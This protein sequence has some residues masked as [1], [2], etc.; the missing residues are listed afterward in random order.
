MPWLEDKPENFSV[1]GLLAPNFTFFARIDTVH[2][3]ITM[4]LG[5][6]KTRV[7]VYSLLPKIYFNEPDFEERVKAYQE[8]Q[9]RVMSEDRAML[10]SMQNGLGS[11]RFAPGRMAPIE[12]GVQ[13]V[14]T[15]YL[16]RMFG[17]A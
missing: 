6:N 8:Y 10:D 15:G 16:D 5:L 17:T 4:P 12:H 1:T 9:A 11:A 7:T 2:P 3:Y 13:Q 14:L